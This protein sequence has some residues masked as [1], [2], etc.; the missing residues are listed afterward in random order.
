MY[1]HVDQFFSQ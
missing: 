1:R